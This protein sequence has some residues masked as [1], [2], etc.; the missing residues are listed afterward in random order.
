MCVF[1]L[2]SVDVG[3]FVNN[4]DKCTEPNE[5]AIVDFVV[6]LL[7][8]ILNKQIFEQNRINEMTVGFRMVEL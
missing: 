1:A 5:M 2:A 4:N 3:T 8:I 7:Q 6:F